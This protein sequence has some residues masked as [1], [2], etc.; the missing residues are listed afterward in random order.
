VRI[1]SRVYHQR[2]WLFEL[3]CFVSRDQRAADV[4]HISAKKRPR[5]VLGY[6]TCCQ[7]YG[8]TVIVST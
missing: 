4:K 6:V 5:P 3:T 7:D 8:V 2:L 1:G